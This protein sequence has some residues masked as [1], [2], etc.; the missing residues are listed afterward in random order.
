MQDIRQQRF[1][2]EQQLRQQRMERAIGGITMNM[3]KAFAD[4]GDWPVGTFFTLGYA[5]VQ[6]G[7]DMSGDP[8][9]A[10]MQGDPP[11]TGDSEPR[12][13][14]AAAYRQKGDFAGALAELQKIG[15]PLVIEVVSK[16]ATLQVGKQ[17]VEA[18][19][20]GESLH[21]TKVDG[22][23]LWVQSIEGRQ[24]QR[25]GWIHRKHVR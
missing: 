2:F 22:D 18:V 24:L 13:V 11:G 15:Q 4:R 25:P 20:E 5:V 12:D 7:A 19:S 17:A 23:W 6:V 10:W 3:Q 8:L 14:A 16:S 9:A 21:V 1:N